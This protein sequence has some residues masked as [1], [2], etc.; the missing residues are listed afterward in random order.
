MN[1]F[2][3]PLML[4]MYD[5]LTEAYASKSSTLFTREGARRYGTG[6]MANYF[7]Q[8]FDGLGNW[9]DPESHRMLAYACYRA[10]QDAAKT[11]EEVE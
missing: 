11:T 3:N 5:A 7:W 10:G 4:R 6:S 9:D 8:G 2:R 1:K